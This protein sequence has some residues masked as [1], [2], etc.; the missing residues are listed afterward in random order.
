VFETN[1]IVVDASVLAVT[2]GDD[3]IDGQL[4]RRRLVDEILAAPELIDLEVTSVWRRQVAARL[5]AARRAA[6]AISD[7]VDLPLRGLPH[8]PLLGRIWQLRQV[9]TP[10]DAAYVALAEAVSVMLITADKRLA[11]APGLKCEV[12]VLGRRTAVHHEF[13]APE[14]EQM[15]AETERGYLELPEATR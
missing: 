13:P 15:L 10:Y 9:V 4:A 11:R 6:E 7:L 12:E 14:I 8:R 2:L 1:V 3:S 5:M